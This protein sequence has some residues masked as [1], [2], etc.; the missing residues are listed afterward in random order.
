MTFREWWRRKATVHALL[1]LWAGLGFAL[2]PLFGQL[3]FGDIFPGAAPDRLLVGPLGWIH[4]HVGLGLLPQL[5]IAAGL[6]W[7]FLGALVVALEWM[8]WRLRVDRADHAWTSFPWALRSWPAW[9]L[10]TLGVMVVACLAWPARNLEFHWFALALL[11][12]AVAVATMPFFSFNVDNLRDDVPRRRFR[13][14]WPGWPAVAS[15]LVFMV[16]WWLADVGVDRFDA[17]VG[18][19]EG[20]LGQVLGVVLWVPFLL[21]ALVWQVAWLNRAPL[22]ATGAIRRR[23]LALPVVSAAVVQELRYWVLLVPFG[24]PLVAAAIAS[25]FFLPQMEATMQHRGDELPAAWQALA[26][27][28]RFVGPWYWLV[29]LPLLWFSQVASARLLVQL[30]T[31]DAKDG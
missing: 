2:L 18:G 16:V 21:W 3:H 10:W 11:P 31:A 19:G 1:W 6:G 8:T 26:T 23:A 15:A 24:V 22:A 7:L 9:R 25:L 13:A 29:V 30:G 14:R 12:G 28:A 4:R 20:W 17:I 5:W 27:T